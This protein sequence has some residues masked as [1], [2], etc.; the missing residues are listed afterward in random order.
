MEQHTLI[1][2]RLLGGSS[3]ELLQIGE[4]IALTHHEKWDGTGYPRGLAGEDIPL[5]GRICAVADVFDALTSSRPY[6]IAFSNDRALGILREGRGTHFDPII[7]DIFLT[8]FSEVLQIQREYCDPEL[9]ALA[10]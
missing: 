9:E 7:L 1:G 10:A 4:C 6:K 8:H 2:A 3:S 5:Y